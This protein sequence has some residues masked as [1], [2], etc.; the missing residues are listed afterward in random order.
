MPIRIR[1][2]FDA[3]PDPTS[4]YTQVE[5]FFYL[6]TAMSVYIK[7]TIFTELFEHVI[8]KYF[9]RVFVMYTY[10]MRHCIF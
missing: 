6:F 8:A 5:I 10:F 3:D 9:F 1:L 2:S 4:S 7:I